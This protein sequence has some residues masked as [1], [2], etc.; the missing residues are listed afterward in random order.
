MQTIMGNIDT[1][2]ENFSAR[3]ENVEGSVSELSERIKTVSTKDSKDNIYLQL[4]E[5]YAINNNA[6]LSTIMTLVV[7]LI[8]VI[9][10]FGNVFVKTEN[11]LIIQNSLYD[12]KNECFSVVALVLTYLASISILA[13]LFCL[14]TYQ[15]IAQRK[16]Q[17]IIHAIR[18]EYKNENNDLLPEGYHPYK[19]TKFEIIQG[20]YGELDKFF[21]IVSIVLTLCLIVK[22]YIC[23]VNSNLC[24]CVILLIIIGLLFLSAII[25]RFCCNYYR[26]LYKSY[27]DRQIEYSEKLKNEK[28]DYILSHNDITNLKKPGD[29]DIIELYEQIVNKQDEETDEKKDE[30]ID[31][32]IDEN[33]S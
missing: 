6:N 7:A 13:I 3:L 21:I 22:I 16:E 24:V 15:G 12:T 33:A 4:H 26:K 23:G 19:K 25:G 31:E 17:F 10:C 29:K 11:V 5:Q 20:L 27:I 8:V 9:G 1:S 2:Q 14:C 28:L 18:N 30:K 32:K